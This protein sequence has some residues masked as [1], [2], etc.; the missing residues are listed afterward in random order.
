MLTQPVKHVYVHTTGAGVHAGRAS[1][2]PTASSSRAK[3]SAS[4]MLG[5]GQQVGQQ[6]YKAK[7]VPFKQR[8]TSLEHVQIDTLDPDP[9]FPPGFEPTLRV[10]ST[11]EFP[12]LATESNKT[13]PST[14]NLRNSTTAAGKPSFSLA[15]AKSTEAPSLPTLSQVPILPPGLNVASQA[16]ATAPL[17]SCVHTA[18][19]ESQSHEP[20]CNSAPVFAHRL[21]NSNSQQSGTS[22][23]QPKQQGWDHQSGQSHQAPEQSGWDVDSESEPGPAWTVD[24][25]NQRS[26]DSRNQQDN[27]ASSIPRCY[28]QPDQLQGTAAKITGSPTPIILQKPQ[29]HQRMHSI[30]QYSP[31]PHARSPLNITK[32]QTESDQKTPIQVGGWNPDIL[33]GQKAPYRVG[34]WNP[35][36]YQGTGAATYDASTVEKQW[37]QPS[38]VQDDNLNGLLSFA[39]PQASSLHNTSESRKPAAAHALAEQQDPDLN[40]SLSRMHVQRPTTSSASNRQKQKLGVNSTDIPCAAEPLLSQKASQMQSQQYQCWNNSSI[41]QS[42]LETSPAF[43]HGFGL[44]PSHAR[45]SE[46]ICAQSPSSTSAKDSVHSSITEHATNGTVDEYSSGHDRQDSL[47]RQHI[48]DAGQLEGAVPLWGDSEGDDA[49]EVQPEEGDTKEYNCDRD[50]AKRGDPEGDDAEGVSPEE[51]DAKGGD[52]EGVDRGNA[53]QVGA[54]RR[55]FGSSQLNCIQLCCMLQRFCDFHLLVRN[56]I[57]LPES[58]LS[59]LCMQMVW[60]WHAQIIERF[61]SV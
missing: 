54:K 23:E 61:C 25:N 59:I 39:F 22:N 60:D 49:E 38:I 6:F 58:A 26:W 11:Q 57:L 30:H 56:T 3:S 2:S 31:D 45:S 28:W 14:P 51:D 10:H 8:L 55:A 12:G 13:H 21:R 40:D 36:R 7:A 53:T 20:T 19:A 17:A 46:G 48:Q 33:Q 37:Q 1:K 32:D 24:G 41:S 42:R 16:D 47:G 35:D 5:N 15:A 9:E 4:V 43:P 27:E 52:P 44:C 18:E 29:Q 50:G 34:G